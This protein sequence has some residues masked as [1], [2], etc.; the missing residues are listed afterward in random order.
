MEVLRLEN[1]NLKD[2]IREKD[3]ILDNQ[4]CSND[5]VMNK[6]VTDNNE[7]NTDSVSQGLDRQ[8]A[9]ECRIEYV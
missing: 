8:P 5:K 6:C 7:H 1:H 2:M 9:Q 3:E 4:M